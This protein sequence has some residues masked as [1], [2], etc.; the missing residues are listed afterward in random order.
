[1]KN[2]FIAFILLASTSAFA[3]YNSVAGSA[4]YAGIKT[5]NESPFRI[6]SFDANVSALFH[7]RDFDSLSVRD[8]QA[9]L[10]EAIIG[11]DNE[12][13]RFNF[14]SFYN[15][16]IVMPNGEVKSLRGF[17]PIALELNGMYRIGDNLYLKLK[18]HGNVST[19]DSGDIIHGI[20][21]SDLN[22]IMAGN[23][24]DNCVLTSERGDTS[25]KDDMINF[26]TEAGIKYYNLQLTVFA[27]RAMGGGMLHS[28]Q[29]QQGNLEHKYYLDSSFRQNRLGLRLDYDLIKD[30]PMGNLG[31]FASA[32]I[33]NSK[34]SYTESHNILRDSRYIRKSY[35]V[36]SRYPHSQGT[37]TMI[38][39]G[40]KWTIPSKKK[41]N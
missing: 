29:V 38:E 25:P 10:L 34:V 14:I 18:A 22:S 17:R 36:E 12:N 5:G 37:S 8:V 31:V 32:A 27:D 28:Y 30:K 41:K 21:E 40:V 24:C 23:T 16:Q 3:Q 4:Q 19:Q 15:Q 6:L 26:K 7:G 11:E 9:T 33:I 13:F 1:M 2:T 20:S 39:A 35:G